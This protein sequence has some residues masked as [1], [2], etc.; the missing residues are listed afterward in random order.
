MKESTINSFINLLNKIKASGLSIAAYCEKNDDV[1]SPS[2]IYDK[3]ANFKKSIDETN[4]H[5]SEVIELYN[6]IV[7]PKIVSKD[8]IDTDNRSEINYLR[9]EEGKIQSY[10]FAIYRKDKPTLTGKFSR[11]EMSMIYRLYSI[12]GANLTQREVNR[13]FPQYSIVD[14]RRI[15]R[16]FEIYKSNCPFPRHILEETSSEEL[17]EMQLREK[18]NDFLVKTE[19]NVIKQNALLLKKY[20]EENYRLKNLLDSYNAININVSGL[21][22][23]NIEPLNVTN[24]TRALNLYLSDFHIGA[25]VETSSL[26]NENINFGITEITRRLQQIIAQIETLGKFDHINI[27]LMGDMIDCCGPS[28]QTARLDHTLPENLNG[29]EQVRVYVSLMTSFINTIIEKDFCNKINLYSV[30]CGNHSGALEYAA[31]SAIFAMF[32]G[33]TRIENVTLFEKFFGVFEDQGH[34]FIIT[35][36]KDDKYMKQGLPLNLDDKNKVKIYEWL[37]DNNI[38]GNNIHIIKGD[39]HSSNYSSCHKFDYRNVLSLFGAS[40]YSAYNFSRNSYGVSYEIIDECGNILRGEMQ[41][42]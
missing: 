18:E 4:P 22:N 38:T 31:T 11:D 21:E 35:H 9:D 2:A 10:E 34:T 5:Y 26:Y 42:M 20:A 33:H 7:N 8:N 32:A 39:L 17:Q 37:I 19:Q 30:K 23:W 36:G 1:K 40:D 3:F 15:L 25:N 13:Y 24:S 28:N 41:N 14:F 16:T 27:C 29:F 6:S 12:Y